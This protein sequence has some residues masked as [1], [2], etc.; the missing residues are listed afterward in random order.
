MYKCTGGSCSEHKTL[1]NSP[2]GREGW[3]VAVD[4]AIDKQV[5]SISTYVFI[6][7]T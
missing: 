6:T 1:I 2:Q 7:N 4:R 5:W 3:K